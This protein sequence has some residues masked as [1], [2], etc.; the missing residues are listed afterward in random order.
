MTEPLVSVTMV[1]YNVSP[2]IRQA[3]E[4]V[5]R[6]K[7]NFPFELVIGED[8]STDGTREIILEYRDRYPNTIRVVS[9]DKNVGL[10]KNYIRT[11][12]ACRGKYIAFCDGDDFWQNTE[13]LQKQISHLEAHSTCGLV[14]SDYDVHFTGSGR[15]INNFIKHRKW[16]M[17]QDWTVSEFIACGGDSSLGILTCNTVIRSELYKLISESDPFLH[18]SCHFLLVDT[19]IWAEIASI[20]SVHF[21]P[22]SMATYNITSESATRSG[23]PKKRLRFA[24]SNAE[25]MLYLCDKYEV[26]QTIRKRYLRYWCGSSLRLSFYTLDVTIATRVK[27]TVGSLSW[28]EWILYYGTKNRNF[29][30]LCQIIINVRKLFMHDHNDWA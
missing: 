19:Q 27:A 6:Q 23:D 12:K 15:T 21:I 26:S 29:N 3:I 17:P 22:E 5:L 16:D 8:C 1:A 30:I 7:T 4:S 13:K 11:M 25:L 10:V 28:K 24:M 14:Y 9:S 20:S 18:Q 2:L